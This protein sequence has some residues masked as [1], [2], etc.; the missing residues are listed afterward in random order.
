MTCA[1]VASSWLHDSLPLVLIHCAMVSPFILNCFPFTLTGEW[2]GPK[3]LKRRW[4]IVQFIR[5]YYVMIMAK[6]MFTWLHHPLKLLPSAFLLCIDS[7][8]PGWFHIETY[9]HVLGLWFANTAVAKSSSRVY[10]DRLVDSIHH[11]Q[12][13]AHHQLWNM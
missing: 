13:Q 7:S 11:V 8:Q 4:W 6:C 10:H 5:I 1:P 12:I 3:L 9:L 2:K